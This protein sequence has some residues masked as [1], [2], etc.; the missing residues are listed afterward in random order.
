MLLEAVKLGNVDPAVQ[1]VRPK[2]EENLSVSSMPIGNP[3]TVVSLIEFLTL[4]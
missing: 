2:P 1:T 4:T 3:S